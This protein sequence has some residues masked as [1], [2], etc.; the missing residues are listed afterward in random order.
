M[1]DKVRI[2][3][4]FTS[5]QGEGLYVGLKQL[6]IRF[7]RCN[8]NCQYCDTDFRNSEDSKEYSPEELDEE[9]NVMDI[10]SC[11]SVVLTGGEP[12]LESAF[13]KEFLPKI[14]SYRVY[15][16]TNGILYYNLEEVIDYIDIISMDYKLESATGHA[17]KHDIHKRFL[18]IAK[19]HNKNVFIKVVF[20]SK[21]TDAEISKVCELASNNKAFICLQPMM[22]NGQMVEDIN[23]SIEI[24]DKFLNIYKNVRLIPQ[25]HTL[26]GLK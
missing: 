24:M 4:I 9:I 1:T 14:S 3:E 23:T 2:R 16:E 7:S 20:D 11:H 19:Q 21:I 22:K 26:I 17:S 8:L 10:D 15:L 25:V 6:F 12:L 5:I 13:L 18:N